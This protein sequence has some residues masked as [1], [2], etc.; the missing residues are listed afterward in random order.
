MTIHSVNNFWMSLSVW[1]K[2]WVLIPYLK[3][4][5]TNLLIG[6]TSFKKLTPLHTAIMKISKSKNNYKIV[7]QHVL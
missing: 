2:M 7:S 4:V 3:Y 5:F 1:F 6:V